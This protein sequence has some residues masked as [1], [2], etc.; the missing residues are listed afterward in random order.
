MTHG[1]SSCM[2]SG[3]AICSA[4]FRVE[5]NC[6]VLEMAGGRH[7]RQRDPADELAGWAASIGKSGATRRTQ[8]LRNFLFLN[9]PSA[10]RRHQNLAGVALP[11]LPVIRPPLVISVRAVLCASYF[12]QFQAAADGCSAAF[13]MRSSTML[14]ALLLSQT[15][16]TH[17][18]LTLSDKNIDATS[19]QALS[20][21][22]NKITRLPREGVFR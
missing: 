1:L 10:F 12:L 16:A 2:G 21:R 17:A 3:G 22:A 9:A 19:D 15:A 8:Q 18:A 5:Q 14:S 4:K 13:P 20:D 7:P 6:P 11:F